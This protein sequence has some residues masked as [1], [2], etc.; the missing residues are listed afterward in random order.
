[1]AD[2]RPPYPVLYLC[3][4]IAS[5]ETLLARGRSAL[6]PL[7]G[8][9]ELVSPI[10]PFDLTGY[11]DDVM[12]PGL[13]KQFVIAEHLS[14]PDRLPPLKHATNAL[15]SEFAADSDLPRPINLDPG[16]LTPAKLVLASM[17]DFAH[18]VY[19]ADN[20][21]AE[22]TLTYRHN[23]W[24]PADWTF[25]DFADGR[26]FDFFDAGRAAYARKLTEVSA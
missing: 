7:L 15:E 19:L 14:P 16:Y 6:E 1:M 22:P 25:P 24:R 13:L 20:V 17:K 23:H 26:Y 21:Y 9:I 10:Y 2:A 4:L 8:P 3:G 12:G 18:R 5:D 11:Y